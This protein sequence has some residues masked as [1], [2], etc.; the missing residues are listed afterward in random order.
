[1]FLRRMSL[2]ASITRVTS[3]KFTVGEI[4][5]QIFSRCVNGVV[6]DGHRGGMSKCDELCI[7]RVKEI[8]FCFD[9]QRNLVIAHSGHNGTKSETFSGGAPG[10]PLCC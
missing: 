7:L 8:G 2:I 3:G 1:L 5:K 4:G 6:G 10:M 9:R